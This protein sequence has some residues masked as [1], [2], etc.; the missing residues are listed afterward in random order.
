MDLVILNR[1]KM[2]RMTPDLPPPF[3]NFRTTAAGGR[4]T[5]EG[6]FSVHQTHMHRG[7]SNESSFE[8]EASGPEAETLPPIHLRI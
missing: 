4:L 7:S 3:P 1:G 8:P 6:E 2:A 5:H